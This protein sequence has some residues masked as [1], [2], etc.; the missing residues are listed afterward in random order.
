MREDLKNGLDRIHEVAF[1]VLSI[2]I[3]THASISQDNKK[4]KDE[5]RQDKERRSEREPEI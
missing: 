3:E 1:Y 5:K 4:K 2:G